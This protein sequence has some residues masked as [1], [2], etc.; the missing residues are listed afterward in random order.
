MA[1]LVKPVL[2]ILLIL[3]HTIVTHSIKVLSTEDKS[4]KVTTDKGKVDLSSIAK[5]GTYA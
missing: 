1:I 4:C 3:T 2:L 5:S